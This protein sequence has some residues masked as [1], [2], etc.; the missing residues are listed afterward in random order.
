MKI[1]VKV[2]IPV[3]IPTAEIPMLRES[4]GVLTTPELKARIQE[5]A[6]DAAQEAVE[7]TSIRVGRNLAYLYWIGIASVCL[8][9]AA[10]S[11]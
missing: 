11:F 5:G 7:S 9:G 2:T 4:L 1:Q 3:E 6:A 10:K 8:I